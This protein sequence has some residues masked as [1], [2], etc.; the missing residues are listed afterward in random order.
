M[1]GLV[2]AIRVF[3]SAFQ[4]KLGVFTRRIRHSIAEGRR[5]TPSANP[6]YALEP[7]TLEVVVVVK[8]S[9]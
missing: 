8:A 2:P 5:I 6:S 1:A 4:S 3:P 9:P 7:F